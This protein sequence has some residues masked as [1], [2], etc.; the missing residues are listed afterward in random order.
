MQV[1]N[2]MHQGAKVCPVDSSLEAVALTMWNEDTGAIPLI[3]EDSRLV[4]LV[5]DRDIAMAAALKHRPLWEINARE[6]TDGKPC[7]FCH[8]DEDIHSV[9]KTMGSLQIRRMPVV[10]TEQQLV[11]VV[12]IKDLVEHTTSGRKSGKDALTAS[13]LLSLTRMICETHGIQPAS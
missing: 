8:E 13:E 12:S 5:T 2:V 7:H 1:K 3:A 10:N 4:G 11:G 6:L 9:M